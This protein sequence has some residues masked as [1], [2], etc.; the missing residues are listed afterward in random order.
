MVRP[1]RLLKLR[2]RPPPRIR[3][4]LV[5]HRRRGNL[6]PA[7]AEVTWAMAVA[8]AAAAVAVA[9]VAVA[10]EPA[11]ERMVAE[12]AAAVVAVAERDPAGWSTHP[13]D[14]RAGERVTLTFRGS[15]LA[16]GDRA[17]VVS[18]G[19]ACESG[20]ELES[21]GWLGAFVWQSAF[22][23]SATTF[24]VCHAGA[25]QGWV[26]V[27]PDAPGMDV[28]AP[29]LPLGVPSVTPAGA[30]EGQRVTVEID[31][32]LAGT[33]ATL[34][35]VTPAADCNASVPDGG[36]C[37][38]VPAAA[39][40]PNCCSAGAPASG[41][42]L[43]EGTYGLCYL[44]QGGTAV[45]VHNGTAPVEIVV[46]PPNPVG[47]A[48]RPALPR[49]GQRAAVTVVAA[50]GESVGGA[51]AAARVVAVPR[52]SAASDLLCSNASLEVV[53]A[54]AGGLTPVNG[55]GD[56]W[57]TADFT[58]AAAP[59]LLA[60]VDGTLAR[61]VVCYRSDAAAGW[62]S[63]PPLVRNDS[64]V[65]MVGVHDPRH[66]DFAV[67]AAGG[68]D[69]PA[70]AREGVVNQRLVLHLLNGSGLPAAGDS[71][72]VH[73]TGCDE[74]ALWES[75]CVQPA[76][77]ACSASSG[78]NW[79][80]QGSRL[81]LPF[82]SDVSE[83]GLVACYRR[84]SEPV[85]EVPGALAMLGRDPRSYA[86]PA[87]ARAG[88]RLRLLFNTTAGVP[89]RDSFTVSTLPAAC[90]GAADTSA[91]FSVVVG[92]HASG[93][94]VAAE[95]TFDQSGEF[96][97]CYRL[98]GAADGGWSRVP[99][100]DSTGAGTL[101]VEPPNPR[102]WQASPSPARFTGQTLTLTLAGTGLSVGDGVMLVTD[103]DC[104]GDAVHGRWN[105]TAATNTSAAV[106]FYLSAP[107][108]FSVCYL[109]SDAVDWARVG[110][111]GG[112]V[113]AA[114]HPASF[115]TVP[116][117]PRPGQ[118]V[119]VR[120]TPLAGHA[121][122]SQDRVRL[123]VGAACDGPLVA[124]TTE[125]AVVEAGAGT[126]WRVRGDGGT[127]Y[128]AFS[129][130]GTATV[131]YKLSSAG[132]GWVRVG[133][134]APSSTLVVGPA[135]P[136]SYHV[137]YPCGLVGAVDDCTA[138]A[139][140]GVLLG[141]PFS[142]LFNF[143]SELQQQPEQ[144][145]SSAWLVHAG[146][147]CD[148]A[149]AHRLDFGNVFGAGDYLRSNQTAVA[150]SSAANMTVCFQLPAATPAVVGA[151]LLL[152]PQSVECPVV[153]AADADL[154]AVAGVPPRIGHT[155]VIPSTGFSNAGSGCGAGIRIV[156]HTAEPNCHDLSEPSLAPV[157]HG[158]SGPAFY[159][160]AS[161]I[162]GGLRVC[163]CDAGRGVWA[164]LC[165]ACVGGCAVL[166]P[167]AATPASVSIAPSPAF[168][169]QELRTEVA[170]TDLCSGD[171]LYFVP[172]GGVSGPEP[173]TAVP[174]DPASAA[175]SATVSSTTGVT[176]QARFTA[177][178]PSGRYRTC[179][180]RRGL[181]VT[182]DGT[183]V[184]ACGAGN[185]TEPAAVV[186][187]G[188]FVV[189]PLADCAAV[190]AVAAAQQ[191]QIHSRKLTAVTVTPAPRDAGHSPVTL[192]AGARIVAGGSHC[193][194][195]T[196]A[197]PLVPSL[198]ELPSPEVFAEGAGTYSLCVL[199]NGSDAQWGWAPAC[200]LDVLPPAPSGCDVHPSPLRAGQV[201]SVS[202]STAA[203]PA[204][205]ELA[206]A[207]QSGPLVC[208]GA[209]DWV[210]VGEAPSPWAPAAGVGGGRL[211]RAAAQG[212]LTLCVREQGSE[213]RRAIHA[214]S[215]TAAAASPSSATTSTCARVGVNF[216]ATATGFTAQH[217]PAAQDRAAAVAAAADCYL[218]GD[219]DGVL[220]EPQPDGTADAGPFSYSAPGNLTL[221]Y[222]AFNGSWAVAG[223]FTVEDRSPSAWTV[224]PA[225]PRLG[226]QL[227]ITLSGGRATL[228]PSVDDVFVTPFA[229]GVDADR[230]CREASDRTQLLPATAEGNGT[231]GA[232]VTQRFSAG[233]AFL[234]CYGASGCSAASVPPPLVVGDFHPLRC[235][236]EPAAPRAGSS[237]QVVVAGNEL[238]NAS[239]GE[240]MKL[241][242]LSSTCDD[243]P[244]DV[245]AEVQPPALR[246][247]NETAVHAGVA[248]VA[249]G[250]AADEFA[251]DR[252]F[253]VC[254]RLVG[255]V[256]AEVGGGCTV[257]I[258]QRNPYKFVTDPQG[259]P[260][261]P[262]MS[263]APS[264]R[265]V[266]F[267]FHGDDLRMQDRAAL[268]PPGSDCERELLS[269]DGTAVR[270]VTCAAG[271]CVSL[272]AE[273]L[274]RRAYTNHTVC[275]RSGADGVWKS[276]LNGVAFLE[277]NPSRMEV[278]PEPPP[279]P[280]AGVLFSVRFHAKA[281]SELTRRGRLLIDSPPWPQTPTESHS[282]S[283]RLP[284]LDG[285]AVSV[286]QISL[287]AANYSVRY[288]PD[289]GAEA[290]LF[291][292][293][294]VRPNPHA[295][296]TE[297]F[298]ARLRQRVTL[299]LAGSGLATTVTASAAGVQATPDCVTVLPFS[300]EADACAALPPDAPCTPSGGSVEVLSALR[301]SETGAQV[302][303]RFESL[304]DFAVC[305]RRGG[306]A[307]WRSVSR[308]EC[309]GPACPGVTVSEPSPSPY[310]I[311]PA[312]PEPGTLIRIFI[313]YPR[314]VAC[315]WQPGDRVLL[316]PNTSA[317]GGGTAAA[318]EAAVQPLP[319][320]ADGSASA[321][322]F[323]R[324]PPSPLAASYALC[325]HSAQSLP[326]G[327]Y[328]RMQNAAG[329]DVPVLLT[330]PDTAALPAG[331]TL[332]GGGGTAAVLLHRGGS[333]WEAGEALGFGW[334]ATADACDAAVLAADGLWVQPGSSAED[335]GAAAEA[336]EEDASAA[337]TPVPSAT[338]VVVLRGGA[339]GGSLA[340]CQMPSEGCPTPPLP[341]AGSRFVS[342][343]AV[344]PRGVAGYL[345]TPAHP[346]ANATVVVS[347]SGPD[348]TAADELTVVRFGTP[349]ATGAAAGRVSAGAVR[350]NA[351]QFEAT[352]PLVGQPGY[353]LCYRLGADAAA[354]VPPQPLPPLEHAAAT[355]DTEAAWLEPLPAVV[356]QPEVRLSCGPAAG[357]QA[358]VPLSPPL[359][360]VLVAGTPDDSAA[361][362][363][364]ATVRP[365][366]I[367][368]GPPGGGLTGGGGRWSVG[369][370]LSFET[371]G[372]TVG[373]EYT[374]VV[375]V[376]LAGGSRLE[377]A[378]PVSA[379]PAPPPPSPP[380]PPAPLP[381]PPPPPFPSPPPA[382]PTAGPSTPP[383][384]KPVVRAQLLIP[385]DSFLRLSDDFARAC[386][387]SLELGDDK[388]AV[389][390]VCRVVLLCSAVQPPTCHLV[391]NETD[392]VRPADPAAR[393]AHTLADAA[394]RVGVEVA[395][396]G[397]PADQAG[398]E[399]V[400]LQGMLSLV[401]PA[402]DGSLPA[403]APPLLTPYPTAEVGT[404]FTPSS[405][406]PPTPAP[407]PQTTSDPTAL[408]DTRAPT[409]A[410]QILTPLWVRER[411]ENMLPIQ[412]SAG[413]TASVIPG[414]VT[415]AT[416]TGDLALS[417]GLEMLLDW[418]Y[419]QTRIQAVGSL[420]RREIAAVLGLD[421]SRLVGFVVSE[422][423][424]GTRVSFFI[425]AEGSTCDGTP[426][427]AGSPAPTPAPVAV[428]SSGGG[429]GSGEICSA[430]IIVICALLVLF[431]A[432][433]VVI[434]L[435][436]RRRNRRTY[437]IKEG[438]GGPA[439]YPQYPDLPA[440]PAAAPSAAATEQ[441]AEKV[442]L[443]SGEYG[444]LTF[445]LPRRYDR[446]L[447]K[448]LLRQQLIRTGAPLDCVLTIRDASGASAEDRLCYDE[449]V[450]GE[451]LTY[452]CT[453]PP[454][455]APREPA[456]APAPGSGGAS[457]PAAAAGGAGAGAGAGG[458]PAGSSRS[459]GSA[460]PR[461]TRVRLIDR[462]VLDDGSVAG[463]SIGVVM[464]MQDGAFDVAFECDNEG[465]DV[466]QAVRDGEDDDLLK[467]PLYRN[468]FDVLPP[469][470]PRQP[471]QQAKPTP[472]ETASS[473]HSSRR[474]QQPS[475]GK[476]SGEGSGGTAR[477]QQPQRSVSQR[478]HTPA[479]SSADRDREL[480]PPPP[481]AGY[482][483]PVLGRSMDTV[484]STHGLQQ[485][486]SV[487]VAGSQGSVNGGWAPQQSPTVQDWPPRELVDA[488]VLV[489]HPSSTG[490][491]PMA[492]DQP[493]PC[494]TASKRRESPA[495]IRRGPM[496]VGGF[497][498]PDCPGCEG[499]VPPSS[500]AVQPP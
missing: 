72:S 341:C 157:V 426:A 423:P 343:I 120:F 460:V 494:E 359:T 192:T 376:V 392:C 187:G 449:V 82:V 396:V 248:D 19:E 499:C 145:G 49:M 308:A 272:W 361:A 306:Q 301:Q 337:P 365:V 407:T 200:T 142:V 69:V 176:A 251:A 179:Y 416:G 351:V 175:A 334:G 35:V 264:R 129:E 368:R 34:L 121:L 80:V 488:A 440:P 484:A 375:A 444:E 318:A 245:M 473:K 276:M 278:V 302:D 314:C 418:S 231:A 151:F 61:T 65:M 487:R 452:R 12:V 123:V 186:P 471:E 398:A 283:P 478:D 317:C 377:A 149:P 362:A 21:A 378:C 468:E 36:G 446:S 53:A 442:V 159:L 161:E 390:A 191:L 225:S 118:K 227:T 182:A 39:A 18:P 203:L 63:A 28:I 56:A 127:A 40:C 316:V 388:V 408:V 110:E 477:Q 135:M 234:V 470:A 75:T 322:A 154:N 309:D 213:G 81:S 254:Y 280:L 194:L 198:A 204:G 108:A 332:R 91:I 171:E 153:A 130:P 413:V 232:V 310:T 189:S 218:L 435:T 395:V 178:V 54:A 112:L 51:A 136:H 256:Y 293:L 249:P 299:V 246:N 439:E 216:T 433:I 137:R 432:V 174:C 467:L 295:V 64:G 394:D 281:G 374:L 140:A 219:A 240:S 498:D 279:L 420:L 67:R 330:G 124:G 275:Y 453:A 344:R 158:P 320:S 304:G 450:D 242:S 268:L 199:P 60:A 319:L 17:A 284:L 50:A 483:M 95:L 59:A 233:S 497:H 15:T 214:C 160:N 113:V 414:T 328:A 421:S 462:M 30:T 122:T 2:L 119:T 226:Q 11:T 335:S 23:R 207:S 296:S 42:A 33:G 7:G 222:R 170:G 327:S 431:I 185:R 109:R 105:V 166:T 405:V 290:L 482:D 10:A 288:R 391:V 141:E 297:P 404:E 26:R 323:A 380:P 329:Q 269:T 340:V 58:G 257:R 326:S 384:P 131:C 403:N 411:L 24:E 168:E 241:V 369:A 291:P 41:L 438:L 167:A 47:F 406:P 500:P 441:T 139:G 445:T 489:R 434:V 387:R 261:Q 415:V 363:L 333:L 209:A 263:A 215:F 117:E 77:A 221:C 133:A 357:G 277:S 466:W 220:V 144:G 346:T 224:S 236:T 289:S 313:P 16:E 83:G 436:Q 350:G 464:G 114:A 360:A 165:S 102:S 412:L 29:A 474:Q 5:R 253:R 358:G 428:V 162:S 354:G 367:L 347:V 479:A 402:D 243:A 371:L 71:V 430:H 211:P 422:S 386:S 292:E 382:A 342:A 164:P 195:G 339:A 62:S 485:Q 496:G 417:C 73:R 461:G 163:R 57:F 459:V 282:F 97:V 372:V 43:A 93:G 419:T 125:G 9:A 55:S 45:R 400:R 197:A 190:P 393:S 356:P 424:R 352:F 90:D 217:P 475:A 183:G 381:P 155:A 70:A 454:A 495:A 285:G 85:A 147:D 138:V 212:E 20:A 48:V 180:R 345:L 96:A 486:P 152:E 132:A 25:S 173:A 206:V 451:R 271:A 385:F 210:P 106:S 205:A 373:G 493:H 193:N 338:T 202:F 92:L 456:P 196:V 115:A 399:A 427:P 22:S 32:A 258:R 355:D 46:G 274:P 156:R 480:A 250:I 100:L 116:A 88:Q 298:I 239:L 324:I 4:Q 259:P 260:P 229:E 401:Q 31:P 1:S 266:V 111:A 188:T 201:T 76:T 463:G 66:S 492:V 208:G 98:G 287:N 237:F 321:E 262:G 364:G 228:D 128:H 79:D 349:C 247:L 44:R 429:C 348:V 305:Y 107:G 8:A 150:G 267:S 425:C 476:E 27:P 86:A 447:N 491:W 103:G 148:A 294:E 437:H 230:H 181:D 52:G 286:F 409:V 89:S 366:S 455:G 126:E 490:S 469:P 143:T 457:A 303:V 325:Y 255:A 3:H 472:R 448:R 307:T 300:A 172:S 13:A 78:E 99:R 244:A 252:T 353:S 235:A 104:W 169:G 177:T 389:Q 443:L 84:A 311:T 6:G 273:P 87:T 397:L 379:A 184:R 238:L 265:T 38:P 312:A 465:V 37:E 370:V 134:T 331:W 101:V 481:A 410:A 68:D 94:G 14:P 383:P 270:N 336:P 315:G 458:E 74:A 146:T 223:G